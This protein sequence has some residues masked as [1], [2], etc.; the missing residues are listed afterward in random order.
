M[1]PCLVYWLYTHF[2]VGA[3]ASW[4]CLEPG[5]WIVD[6]D[7]LDMGKQIQRVG[8]KLNLT[9]FTFAIVGAWALVCLATLDFNGPF[10]DEGIYITAGLR[11]LEGHGLT[12]GYLG[13]F[14]GSLLWPALAGLGNKVGGL[15]GARAV[16]LALA[17]FAFACLVLAS[18][19]LFG[20]GAAFWTAVA[21]AAS[22][23]VMAVARL[24]VYDA[25]A[26][27]GIAASF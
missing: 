16:A 12:D 8:G 10:M 26:L 7:W 6:G 24:A 20:A 19:N 11:T 9:T 21:F 17:T 14:A 27:T 5:D 4:T 13:W 2:F 18:R 1:T 15:L 25:A 23:P 3:G 22:G